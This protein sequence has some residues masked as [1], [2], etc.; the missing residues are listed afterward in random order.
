[1]TADVLPTPKYRLPTIY[2]GIMDISDHERR[3]ANKEMAR[4]DRASNARGHLR[5]MKADPGNFRHDVLQ[6]EKCDDPF[7]CRRSACP[8]CG[9]GVP[10][11]S[12]RVTGNAQ[13]DSPHRP[14]HLP[15]RRAL[16][17]SYIGMKGQWMEDPFAALPLDEISALRI[18]AKMM[19]ANE[20]PVRPWRQFRSYLRSLLEDEFPDA[21]MR[22]Y[23]EIAGNHAHAGFRSFPEFR[24]G[25]GIR[26]SGYAN[27]P[28]FNLHGNLVMHHPGHT[29]SEVGAILSNAFP[30]DDA[31]WISAP[32]ETRIDENGITWGGIAGWGEYSGFEL[33][34][35]NFL[36]HGKDPQS[37]EDLD[38]Y[39]PFEHD[40]TYVAQVRMRML[41]QWPRP[42]RNFKFRDGEDSIVAN[43]TQAWVIKADDIG[44]V[45]ENLGDDTSNVA[46]IDPLG[47]SPG[48]GRNA[49]FEPGR[50][51][52]GGGTDLHGIVV[53]PDATEATFHRDF[54]INAVR[55]TDASS[56]VLNLED[57]RQGC[58]VA[59]NGDHHG[60]LAGLFWIGPV[61]SLFKEGF[62]IVKSLWSFG[63]KYLTK[64]MP[65]K[66]QIRGFCGRPGID[67]PPWLP[68]HVGPPVSSDEG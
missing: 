50:V 64:T 42:M 20:N 8:H 23:G 27:A 37:G 13:T 4:S 61:L 10:R 54:T 46:P 33:K 19:D 18:M 35:L 41:Q 21:I 15:K 25:S 43:I 38:P 14:S 16:D 5:I 6:I 11:S 56:L 24:V 12:H 17:N 55:H 22:G 59:D 36:A 47:V 68:R 60:S 26:A 63:R 48:D 62:S 45:S 51:V 66:C 67:K 53:N 2:F 57:D 28:C 49:E 44:L 31:F 40:N 7:P 3:K 58:D 9:G 39:A 34:P 32:K 29:R 65:L 52:P 30:G 1:V